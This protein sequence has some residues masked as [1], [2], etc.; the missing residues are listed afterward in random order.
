MAAPRDDP[1]GDARAAGSGDVAED[2]L[3]RVRWPAGQADHREGT[4]SGGG[5][6]APTRRR[7]TG[8]GKVAALR[9]TMSMRRFWARP[10]SVALLAM[11]GNSAYP[12]AEIS[13]GLGSRR[14]RK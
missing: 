4:G 14:P 3:C 2:L 12:A 5:V 13:A 9:T 10:A 8:A 11:G 7:A 6:V 1:A